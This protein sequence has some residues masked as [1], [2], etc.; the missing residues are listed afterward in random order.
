M[1]PERGWGGSGLAPPSVRVE[2]DYI[3]PCWHPFCVLG[4]VSETRSDPFFGLQFLV[5]AGVLALAT[6][7][8]GWLASLLV[9]VLCLIAGTAVLLIA[10][11]RAGAPFLKK[12]LE[13]PRE[14][15]R[16]LSTLVR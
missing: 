13:A 8:G 10:R 7:L 2:K 3:S 4:G 16:W 15:L 1:D 14:D 11:S 12:T 6:Q 9:L 5:V